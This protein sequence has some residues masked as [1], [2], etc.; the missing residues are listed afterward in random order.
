M[1]ENI[2][3]NKGLDLGGLLAWETPR[4]SVGDF[5][6]ATISQ[7]NLP[8]RVIVRV[9]WRGGEQHVLYLWA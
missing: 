5:G 7:P 6:P 1:N 8:Y 4:N 9:K 3:P 2:N